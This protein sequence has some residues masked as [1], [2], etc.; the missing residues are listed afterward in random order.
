[1]YSKFK[2]IIFIFVVIIFFSATAY[3]AS[4]QTFNSADALKEY[5]DRQPANSPDKP[6][7]VTMTANAPMLERIATAITSAGKYVSLNL[8]GNILT[9]IPDNAFGNTFIDMST[10]NM[11]K[12]CDTLVSITIP[13]S[14]KSIGN[15]A[16][17]SCT[18]LASVIIPNGVTS[19]GRGA[20]EDCTGL[21]SV[22]IPDKRKMTH[23]TQLQG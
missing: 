18:S 23:F 9:S 20:F 8:S 11:K 19:I 12:G 13:N 22:T 15:E 1:M 4:A 2:A 5:L 7:R 10:F 17:K 3:T 14:V 16:F 21:T 6:I